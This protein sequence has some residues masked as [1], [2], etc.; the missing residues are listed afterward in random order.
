MTERRSLKTMKN[1]RN[2]SL[3]WPLLKNSKNADTTFLHAHEELGL[4]PRLQI[5]GV[6]KI[7]EGENYNLDQ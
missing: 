7:H 4:P 2:L 5:K 6:Q 3:K 1:K